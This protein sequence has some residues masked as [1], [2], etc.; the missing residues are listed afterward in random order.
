MSS[1]PDFKNDDIIVYSEL[2][3]VKIGDGYVDYRSLHNV[4][5]YPQIEYFEASFIS[6]TGINFYYHNGS[7]GLLRENR[8]YDTSK[9]ALVND[10]NANI[11][12][13][14]TLD[15]CKYAEFESTVINPDILYLKLHIGCVNQI[16]DKFTFMRISYVHVLV[17]GLF[18]PFI[19]DFGETPAEKI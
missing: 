2:G 18:T 5:H 9:G 3:L 1:G 13:Y 12:D 6:S 16:D 15:I 14:D 7:L 17:E 10:D 8:L 4:G 19:T 11:Y